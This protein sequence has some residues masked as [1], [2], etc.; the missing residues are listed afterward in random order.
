MKFIETTRL[1][2]NERLNPYSLQFTLVSVSESFLI[3][4]DEQGHC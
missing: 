2:K 1:R 4:A 3:D